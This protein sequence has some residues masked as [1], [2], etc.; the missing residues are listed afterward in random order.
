M[1][2]RPALDFPTGW[3]D[4]GSRNAAQDRLK[5]V[6]AK[7][8]SLTNTTGSQK[9]TPSGNTP[10]FEGSF[11]TEISQGLQNKSALGSEPQGRGPDTR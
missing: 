3:L 8:G 2:D 6:E 4:T 9:Q 5:G 11:T 10:A 7:L 1:A